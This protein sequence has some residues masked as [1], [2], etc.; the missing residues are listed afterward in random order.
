MVRALNTGLAIINKK[1]ED[2][3]SI[4]NKVDFMKTGSQAKAS[5]QM[6]SYSLGRL[7]QGHNQSF[8]LDCPSPDS[9]STSCADIAKMHRQS[10]TLSKDIEILSS[11]QKLLAFFVHEPAFLFI[12]EKNMQ[13]YF[14][15]RDVYYHYDLAKLEA[16]KTGLPNK[17]F[18]KTF[19]DVQNN[20]VKF[21]MYQTNDQLMGISLWFTST[22]FK[23]VS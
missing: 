18:F 2:S 19:K 5:T 23:G 15:D 6:A 8:T 7:F 12:H 14:P 17:Y 16:F 3:I 20:L 1:S 13:I 10:V 21:M 11:V 4:T 22:T 9:R